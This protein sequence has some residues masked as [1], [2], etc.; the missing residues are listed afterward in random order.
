MKLLSNFSSNLWPSVKK[1]KKK[2]VK[3][4]QTV[5]RAAAVL[6]PSTCD[7]EKHILLQVSKDFTY[8]CDLWGVF[9]AGSKLRQNNFKTKAR[10]QF[11]VFWFHFICKTKT[12]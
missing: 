8:T 9:S 11:D 5:K 6:R 12:Q 2:G 4:E 10:S 3:R 1:Q 7:R